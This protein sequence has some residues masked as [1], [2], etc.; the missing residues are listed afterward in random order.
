MLHLSG[1][2]KI[3]CSK[4]QLGFDIDAF[5][6]DVNE[7][8]SEE[9]EM[10]EETFY[11]GKMNIACPRCRQQI[12]VAYESSEY[13]PGEESYNDVGIEGGK[14]IEWFPGVDFKRDSRLSI[15]Q[16]S[17]RRHQQDQRIYTFED[18]AGILV[19]EK[20][21]II[22]DLRDCIINLVDEISRDPSILPTIPNRQFE[23]LVAHIF[24]GKGFQVELTKRTRDG[25][26]DVIALR[27]DLGVHV[28]YLIECKRYAMPNKVGVSLVRS[29]Y[30]VQAQEGA[31]K[32]VLATT[33]RFTK[34]ALEFASATN[35]T[36]WSMSLKDFDDV[37]DWIKEASSG[38]R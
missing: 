3:E 8:G 19:P 23:E 9:R 12:E 11:F 13:P 22:T 34:E 18:D 14:I 6:L 2:A 36:E 31:N 26:R 15:I 37:F 24:A 4:C 7:V 32:S 20:P 1:L 16:V 35:T 30:G 25:G 10:G 17:N 29:L 28:K 27:N 5:D 21:A 38:K 33:S